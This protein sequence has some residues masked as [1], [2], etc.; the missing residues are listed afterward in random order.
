[1]ASR[2]TL[3][4]FDPASAFERMLELDFKLLLL[5]ADER[6][7]SLVHISEQRLNVPYRYWKDFTG[8]VCQGDGWE[9]RTYRM[10]VRDLDRN[11][12][13]TM[14]RVLPRLQA[15]GIW[16]SCPLN[17]GFVSACL[18][19]DFVVSLDRML[20]EDPWILVKN[21]LAATS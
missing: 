10:F 18:C 21:R 4:A 19:S 17:Y 1:L 20:A 8:Q 3:S 5:G 14:E 11:P 16:Q 6:A 2:D 9:E 15:A 7:I 12:V 13:L